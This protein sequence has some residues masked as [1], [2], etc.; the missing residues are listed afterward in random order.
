MSEKLNLFLVTRLEERAEVI[1]YNESVIS[2][3]ENANFRG[4][5]H[6]LL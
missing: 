4:N 2:S 1:H 5:M 6:R 3:L